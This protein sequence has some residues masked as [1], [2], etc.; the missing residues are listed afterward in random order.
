MR[1]GHE[2][3]LFRHFSEYPAKPP[4]GCQNLHTELP[5]VQHQKRKEIPQTRTLLRKVRGS[6]APVSHVGGISDDNS[7][8]ALLRYFH[9]DAPL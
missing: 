1:R 4:E 5:P 7:K 8:A 6:Q 9:S 2:E 3:H